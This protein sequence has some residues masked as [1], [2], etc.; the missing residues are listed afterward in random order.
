MDHGTPRPRRRGHGTGCVRPHGRASAQPEA[1]MAQLFGT[2]L[3]G[4]IT[5][6]AVQAFGGFGFTDQRGADDAP[7]PGEATY[8]DFKIGETYA[9][10]NEI[11]KWSSPARS[12]AGTSP[13]DPLA[14][15]P[16]P[17]RG[18]ETVRVDPHDVLRSP[19][20][21]RRCDR[22]R[23]RHNLCRT[24]AGGARAPGH[25]SR[26]VGQVAVARVPA[27]PAADRPV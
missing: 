2:R 20:L 12:S 27:P 21:N 3:C 4:D 26:R 15:L 13:A 14:R 6:D 24:T 5:R 11:Q 10:A 7:G 23:P 1:A 9:G 8:R 18:G 22:R 19:C 17:V 16:R 25:T